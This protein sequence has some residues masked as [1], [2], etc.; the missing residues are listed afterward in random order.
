MNMTN[1]TMDEINVFYTPNATAD[2]NFGTL[3][4]DNLEYLYNKYECPSA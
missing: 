1:M 3:L 2:G 4:Q